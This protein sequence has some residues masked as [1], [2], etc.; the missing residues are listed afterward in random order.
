[1]C[2]IIFKFIIRRRRHGRSCR[3]KVSVCVCVC[4][5][6][7]D[8]FTGTTAAAAAFAAIGASKGPRAGRDSQPSW[9]S[10]NDGI[11]YN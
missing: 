1:M 6:V 10:V 7:I 5:R 3:A 2:G 11:P 9:L 4:A 8:D